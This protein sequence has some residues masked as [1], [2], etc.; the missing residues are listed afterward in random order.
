H[1]VYA[2]TVTVADG[3]LT[4]S[5][6][7]TWTVTK[8]ERAPVITAIPNQTSPESAVIGLAVVASDPDG[9]P[10][11]FSATGLPAALTIDAT[12]GLISG[13]LTASGAGVYNVTV[14]ASD[15]TLTAS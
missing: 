13:T 3:T 15:G 7:F 2:V 5:Q 6:S 8:V 10:V 9:D 4:A 11:T 14:T 12:T 1:G